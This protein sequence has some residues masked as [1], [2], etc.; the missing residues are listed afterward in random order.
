[1]WKSVENFL[2]CTCADLQRESHL[3]AGMIAEAGPAPPMTACSACAGD[4]ED[5]ERTAWTVAADQEP[6]E[7]QW[8][9]GE[10]AEEG[11]AGQEREES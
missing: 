5:P 10:A 6:A 9:E 3:C 2:R 1:M 8:P 11:E 4:Y 7:E